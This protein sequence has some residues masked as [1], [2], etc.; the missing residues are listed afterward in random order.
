MEYFKLI[1][2][3]IATVCTCITCTC[4]DVKLYTVYECISVST[5]NINDLNDLLHITT[6]KEWNIN[7]TLS[8]PTQDKFIVALTI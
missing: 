1:M 6:A 8:E 2:N 3:S 7:V 5:D 4:T